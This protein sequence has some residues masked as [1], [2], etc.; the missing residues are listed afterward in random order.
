MPNES[1]SSRSVSLKWLLVAVGVV[2]IV[3]I[4]AY[5]WKSSEC[6][7][8]SEQYDQSLRESAFQSAEMVGRA[9]GTFGNKQIVAGDWGVLQEYADE[10]V[11]VKPV[12]YVAILNREGVANVHTDRSFR[13][14]KFR[15][16]E[17]TDNAVHASIPVMSLTRQVATIRVGVNVG[18]R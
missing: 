13:G 18:Q 11:K 15:E 5:W 1:I 12:P 6:D 2:A 16:P 14:G 7:R 9:I 4:A 3:G 8:M 10:L 17:K